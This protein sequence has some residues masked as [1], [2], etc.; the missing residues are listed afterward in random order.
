MNWF[1]RR[2]LFGQT[3]VVTRTRQQASDLSQQLAELGADVI[4]APT[5]EL[6]PADD[7][8]GVDAALAR[9]AD[10]DW[11]VF[12]SANGVAFTER[13][14]RSPLGLD[15]RA[16]G[17]AKIAAIGDAT[18][19]AVR[20]KLLPERRPLPR[21]RS[22]P[23]RWR[24]HLPRRAKSRASDSCCSAPTSPGRSCASGSSSGGA[25]EVRDVADLRN[26][27]RRR[28]SRSRCSTPSTPARSRGSPSPAAAP[29]RTSPPCSA[30]TTREQ[31]RRH[32]ARQH[33]PDHDANPART[34]P[35]ADR[36]GRHVQPRRPPRRDDP[37]G[38]GLINPFGLAAHTCV[39]DPPE[40]SERIGFVAGTS[41][42]GPDRN[43]RNSHASQNL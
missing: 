22:S 15:A 8:S 32:Q 9:P 21:E 19:A 3:I 26:Q 31:L 7:W 5:I 20:E 18:A 41:H 43:R 13:P 34:G 11:V 38:G 24:T 25:A 40:K 27:T 12:T 16:F 42:G 36:P 17:G 2:P 29:R 28:R 33:R 23:R 6:G 14:T 10:Y 39:R 30:P 37:G 35:G 1:E 4:E